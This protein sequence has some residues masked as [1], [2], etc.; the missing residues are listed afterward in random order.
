MSSAS[1][2]FH[3]GQVV[4]VGESLIDLFPDGEVIG[5]APFNVA[6]NLAA[7]GVAPLMITRVGDD[8]L[9]RQ[10]ANEFD[11]FGLSREGLQTDTTRAT[12]QVLVHCDQGEHRF[13]I[14]PDQAWDAIEADAALGAVSRHDARIVYFGSLA[15]RSPT[16]AATVRAVVEGARSDHGAMRFLDLN[17]RDLNRP[18]GPDNRAL[19]ST[20]LFMADVVKVNRDEL[21][22]LLR[23][24]LPGFDADLLHTDLSSEAA[25]AGVTALMACFG[26]T[27]LVVTC[28]ADGYAAFD[29][30]T[31]LLAQGASPQVTVRDTVGAGDA[32]S[33]VLLLGEIHGWPLVLTLQRAAGFAAAVCGLQGAV[34]TSDDFYASWRKAWSVSASTVGPGRCSGAVTER[35]MSRATPSLIAGLSALVMAASAPGQSVV[36]MWVH[37]G[38]GPEVQAHEAAAQAFNAQNPDIR[39]ELVKL[40]EGSYNDQVNAA[41]LARKLPCVL[42]FDGPQL[43]SYAWTKKILPL[44]GFAELAPIKAD[45]LPSLLRQGSYNG[46]LYSLGQFDSG[47]ALWGSRKLLQRAGVRI[48]VGVSDVWSQTEFETVLKQLKASGVATPLDMKFNYGVGEWYSYGFAPIVQSFGGD[49]IERPGFRRSQGVINGPQAVRALTTLQTWARRGLHQPG[50]QGRC[51]LRQGQGRLVLG[52]PLGLPRLPQGPG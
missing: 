34:S 24:F 35:A 38:A 31:G 4:V 11:R 50:H 23:W 26:T 16:S 12:G 33:S 48:P 13:E 44:D 47:L 39:L 3:P 28:G 49:L 40:P 15:Q 42:E 18:D 6:R 45:M 19:A 43:Y 37:D 20:S 8:L 51:R 14:G 1:T 36:S 52:G 21:V 7:L 22:Q 2:P 32:F 9:G 5:G 17:L 27:R 10:L 30:L 29:R 46:R 41:A 25:V